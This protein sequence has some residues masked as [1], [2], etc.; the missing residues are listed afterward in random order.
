MQNSTTL[1]FDISELDKIDSTKIF[2]QN[3]SNDNTQVM[4][5]WEGD[6]P[7]FVNTLTT[8]GDFLSYDEATTFVQQNFHNW[9]KMQTATAIRNEDGSIAY[10]DE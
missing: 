4:I 2:W 8:K 1:I 10:T 5:A 3:I 7:D 9:V 6:T